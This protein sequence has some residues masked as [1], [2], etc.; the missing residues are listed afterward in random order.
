MRVNNG[1]RQFEVS[2]EQQ[3]Q[4]WKE[5]WQSTRAKYPK[6]LMYFQAPRSIATDMPV[7][8]MEQIMRD[9]PACRV[10]TNRVDVTAKMCSVCKKMLPASHFIKTKSRSVGLAADCRDCHYESARRS[11]LRRMYGLT[12]TQYDEMSELQG[13]LCAIC[14]RI[15]TTQDTDFPGRKNAKRRNLDALCVDHDHVTGKVRGLLCSKCNQAIG[16]L[17]HK[18]EYLESAIAYLLRTA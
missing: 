14:G 18:T 9:Y 11:H 1:W 15:N 10:L 12:P 7:E 8:K 13:G 4:A 2:D 5:A 17:E 6:W 3:F 16:L